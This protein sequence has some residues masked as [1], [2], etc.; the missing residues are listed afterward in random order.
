MSTYTVAEAKNKLSELINRALK[1]EGVVITRHGQPVVELKSVRHVPRAMTEADFEWLRAHRA[2]LTQTKT[3]AGTF[4]S[5]MR[6]EEW[7]R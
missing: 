7:E 2:R 5:Q 3:D 1:G 6:D 4:V